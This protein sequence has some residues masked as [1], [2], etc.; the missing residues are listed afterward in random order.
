MWFEEIIGRSPWTW[1]ATTSFHN[2]NVVVLLWWFEKLFNLSEVFL[3]NTDTLRR[4]LTFCFHYIMVN[5]KWF[6]NKIWTFQV[7]L[8]KRRSISRKPAITAGFGEPR[9]L[10]KSTFFCETIFPSI[11]FFCCPCFALLMFWPG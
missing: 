1:I 11:Y 3:C 4:S 6:Q 8:I 9:N 2:I 7:L 10:C 5:W